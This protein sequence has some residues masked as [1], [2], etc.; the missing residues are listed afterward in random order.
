MKQYIYLILAGVY[1]QTV[2]GIAL[3]KFLAITERE[4][5]IPNGL[6]FVIAICIGL[7]GCF[8]YNRMYMRKVIQ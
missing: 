1:A 7:V 3:N 6:Q 4:L 5:M 2:Y 8:I